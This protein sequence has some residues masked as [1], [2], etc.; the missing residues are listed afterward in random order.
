MKKKAVYSKQIQKRIDKE[1]NFG[2]TELPKRNFTL[3]LNT[4]S[5]MHIPTD[6]TKQIKISSDVRNEVLKELKKY[7]AKFK[8][9][10]PEKVRSLEGITQYEPL[11][12]YLLLEVLSRNDSSLND[13][14]FTSVYLDNE[15]NNYN[16]LLNNITDK[17]RSIKIEFVDKKLVADC[18]KIPKF[19]LKILLKKAFSWPFYFFEIIKKYHLYNGSQIDNIRMDNV[20]KIV[21]NLTE[22]LLT[23]VPASD[24]EA[25]IEKIRLTTRKL[26][27]L[28][29][30]VTETAITQAL[31]GKRTTVLE[32]LGKYK[33]KYDKSSKRFIDLRTHQIIK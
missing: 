21:G 31:N 4:K 33:I 24:R 5:S 29:K 28:N 6:N 14:E 10:I 12:S 32:R 16:C 26:V 1:T 13:Y 11:L 2:K 9:R 30:K 18:I 7:D 3:V 22:N 8:T 25:T 17:S 27:L 23:P 20:D 19:K 15:T